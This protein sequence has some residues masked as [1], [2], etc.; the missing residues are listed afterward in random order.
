VAWNDNVQMVF[1]GMTQVDMAPGLMV[2]VKAGPL[3]RRQNFLV[4]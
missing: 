2:D 4:L 1:R 3:E